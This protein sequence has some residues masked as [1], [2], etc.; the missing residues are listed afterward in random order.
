VNAAGRAARSPAQYRSGV[1]P[2]PILQTHY[3]AAGPAPAQSAVVAGIRVA[4]S[5]FLV[6]VVV[7]SVMGWVWTGANQP[8]ADMAGA[9]T[10]LLLGGLAG[11]GGVV[12]IW[13]PRRREA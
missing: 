11:I 13:R 8:P 1:G 4:I 7:L 5:V 12:V 6:L 9:R 2:G 3:G 10:V